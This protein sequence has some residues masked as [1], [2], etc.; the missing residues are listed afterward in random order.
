MFLKQG[1]KIS[2]KNNNKQ[3]P[4]HF[5]AKYGRYTSLLEFLKNANFKVYVNEKDYDG[6]R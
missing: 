1:A 5:A 3:S 2:L 6:I 4:L